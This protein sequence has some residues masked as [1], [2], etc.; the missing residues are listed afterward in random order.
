MGLTLPAA[1]SSS[2]ELSSSSPESSESEE[3][4]VCRGMTSSKNPRLSLRLGIVRRAQLGTPV[5]PAVLLGRG[6]V[7]DTRHTG[8]GVRIRREVCT[9]ALRRDN[10]IQRRSHPQEQW[11]AP[12]AA[13]LAGSGHS[14]PVAGSHGLDLPPVSHYRGCDCRGGLSCTM[15]HEEDRRSPAC[16]MA[17]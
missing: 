11:Q 7:R 13:S 3:S 14:A 6:Q 12:A 4:T 17:K 2:D 15:E 10:D 9:P 1:R 8:R 5:G 16:P